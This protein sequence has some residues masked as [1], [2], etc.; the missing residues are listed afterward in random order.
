MAVAINPLRI[1]REVADRLPFGETA[2]IIYDILDADTIAETDISWL[3]H[4]AMH[5]ELNGMSTFAELIRSVTDWYE[6]KWEH[7]SR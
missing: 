5:L 4:T 7:E 3:L 2:Q 6:E 1:L